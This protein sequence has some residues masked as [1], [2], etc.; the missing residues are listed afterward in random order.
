MKSRA[1][2]PVGR[3]CSKTKP[4]SNRRVGVSHRPASAA[5]HSAAW[6]VGG[7]YS[8][9]LRR[10]QDTARRHRTHAHTNAFG[11]CNLIGT[12][13]CLAGIAI[14]RSSRHWLLCSQFSRIRDSPI[15]QTALIGPT[16]ALPRAQR[17]GS[18]RQR[19]VERR[20]HTAPPGT[21]KPG[22]STRRCFLSCR[23]FL[24]CL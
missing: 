20:S 9:A 21:W 2:P 4:P 6:R 7:A 10:Q 13:R 8:R 18:R 14:A 22:Q 17:P 16:P 5:I 24:K 12:S 19:G 11:F 23:E 1:S 15:C 3:L